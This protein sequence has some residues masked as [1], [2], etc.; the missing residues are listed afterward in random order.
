MPAIWRFKCLRILF[1]KTCIPCPTSHSSCNL[2]QGKQEEKAYTQWTCFSSAFQSV[3]MVTVSNAVF[4]ELTIPPT[5]CSLAWTR[6]GMKSQVKAYDI[7]SYPPYQMPD[8]L[9]MSWFVPFQFHKC[10]YCAP[11]NIIFL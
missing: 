3:L 11:S 1:S 4:E 7:D 2:P 6:A 10:H 9:K 8:P 5:T